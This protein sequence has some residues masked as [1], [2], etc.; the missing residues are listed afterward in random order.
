ML[1]VREANERLVVATVRAQT[2][3]EEAEN[4][5]RLKDEFLA[6]VSHEL[7]DPA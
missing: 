3:T 5:N 1:Q 2:M 4:A 7:E 6:T